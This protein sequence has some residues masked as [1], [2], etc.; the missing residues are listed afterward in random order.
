MHQHCIEVYHNDGVIKIESLASEHFLKQLKKIRADE[1]TVPTVHQSTLRL[2]F[3][4]VC[5]KC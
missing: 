2:Y 4:T 5:R 1:E 3:H